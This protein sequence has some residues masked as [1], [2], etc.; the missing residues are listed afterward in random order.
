MAKSAGTDNKATDSGNL[1]LRMDNRPWQLS[2]S[3]PTRPDMPCLPRVTCT[4]ASCLV[5][6]T[7]LR[8]FGEI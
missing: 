6:G 2:R 8:C 4:L 7:F 5:H 1:R 3:G